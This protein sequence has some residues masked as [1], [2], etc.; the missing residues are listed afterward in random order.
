MNKSF[1][2]A[3]AISTMTIVACNNSDEHT[4]HDTNAG[5]EPASQADSLFKE[6]MHGHDEAMAAQMTKM[7]SATA[8][9]Q[10]MIDS[11]GKL[12]AKA[13]E[14]AAPYKEKL[15]QILQEL[16]DAGNKMTT[17]MV[18]FNIDSAKDN[19]EQRIKYLADEKLKVNDVKDAIFNSIGKADSL[20]KQK[21]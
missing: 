21:L 19:I 4:H 10:Q 2:L 3:A 15:N 6:V 18:E 13:Q 1:F 7:K 9:I 11:I 8:T 14:E 12:P 16:N 17:W 20:I 5:T